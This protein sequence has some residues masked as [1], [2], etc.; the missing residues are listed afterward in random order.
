VAQA[1]RRGPYW[2]G[3]RNLLRFFRNSENIQ[4]LKRL[5]KE[6]FSRHLTQ[7]AAAILAMVIVAAA[8]A[9]SAWIMRDVVNELVLTRNISKIYLVA[10]LVALIFI[11]KGVAVFIQTLFLSRA[12]NAIVA[13]QQRLLYDRILG[14][15]LEFFHSFQSG[16]LI[17]RMTQNAVAA[18]DVLNALVIS[19]VRDLLSLI[20]LL[21]VMFIQQPFLS[22]SAFLIGPP[23]ILVIALLTRKVKKIAG[24]QYASLAEIVR[25]MQETIFGIKVVKSFNLENRLRGEMNKAVTTS[26]GL[27]NRIA[28]LGAATNPLMETLGGLAIAG[29]IVVAGVLMNS[30]GQTP[31]ALMSF[32]TAL[33]LAYEPAKRLARLQISLESGL[34]GVRMMFALADRP[35]AIAESDGADQLKVTKGEIKFENVTFGYQRDVPVLKKM[36][37]KAAQ[38]KVTALVGPSGGGKSTILNLIL[39]LYDPEAGAVLI[40][41]QDISRVSSASL[42]NA[43]AYVSQDTFLFAGTIRDNIAMGAEGADETAI[44]AAAKAAYAEEFIRAFPGGY[45]TQVGE[46]GVSLS[47]GQKQRIAIARALL[48]NAPIIL[49]DEPTS[50]LDAESEQHVRLALEGLLK[51]RTAM[52]IAHRLSTIRSADVICVI[53][54]GKVAESGTHAELINNESFYSALHDIQFAA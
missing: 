32:L 30:E 11:V 27:A 17:T 52:V 16:D 41:G 4:L 23:A 40:D 1:L 31:G 8:T 13:D 42:R 5:L 36:K 2:S 44:T 49:L 7:Y 46:N 43:I 3:L 20:G 12:G 9:L 26:E 50:A 47:G 35:Y 45:D 51:G 25:I 48:K 29:V 38:G 22:L 39:R 14:H 19:G 28:L 34:A 53:Q 33:L 21:A 54:D 37:L 15:G 24:G 18:R 10:G 6:N